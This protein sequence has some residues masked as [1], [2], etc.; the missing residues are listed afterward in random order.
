MRSFSMVF[1]MFAAFTLVGCFEDEPTGDRP[2]GGSGGSDASGGGDE[3]ENTQEGV[4]VGDADDG[5]SSSSGMNGDNSLFVANYSSYDMCYIAACDC[6]LE[7]CY[8]DTGFWL[9]S[10][11]YIEYSGLPDQCVYVYVEDC[12]FGYYWEN[13]LEIDGDYSWSLY[14]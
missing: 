8:E 3:S 14:D 13:F 12:D 4:D 7:E 2:T 9:P 6:E 11:Y 1:T 5:G 10:G